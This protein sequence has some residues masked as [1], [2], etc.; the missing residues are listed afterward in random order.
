MVILKRRILLFVVFSFFMMHVNATKYYLSASGNDSNKG[1]GVNSPWQTI[2]R[3]NKQKLKPGDVIHF[4]RGDVFRGQINVNVSGTLKKPIVFTAYGE[5]DLPVIS[6]AEV[7]SGWKKYKANIYMAEFSTRIRNLYADNTIQTLARYPNSGFLV[8]DYNGDSIHFKDRDLRQPDGYWEGANVRMRTINWVY[9]TRIVDKY[10]NSSVYFRKHPD[11]PI[12]KGF[13]YRHSPDGNSTI[14][15][16]KLGSGYFFDN[17]FELLDSLGEWFQDEKKSILYYNTNKDIKNLTIESCVYHYG[18]LLNNANNIII[19]NLHL[20]KFSKGCIHVEGKSNNLEIRNN[21]VTNSSRFGINLGYGS[22]NCKISDN[23]VRNTNA[24]GITA[25]VLSNSE[26][27]GNDI[28]RVGLIPG[29][30]WSGNFSPIGILI[31]NKEDEAQIPP[32]SHHNIIKNNRIDSCGYSGIRMDGNNS[33]CEYNFINNCMLTLNDGG[34]FYCFARHPDVTFKNIIRNNIIMNTRG[35][36]ESTPDHHNIGLALYIDNNCHDLTI[37]NNTI[38]N[39]ASS[40]LFINDAVF[41]CTI[42]NNNLYNNS[43]GIA[44]A[45]WN[46]IGGNFGHIVENNTVYCKYKEQKAVNIANHKIGVFTPARMQNN[47]YCN[48]LEKF[49]FR[50]QT[51][52]NSFKNSKELTLEGWQQ[53]LGIDLNSISIDITK[54]DIYKEGAKVFYNDT[55]EDKIIDLSHGEYYN[56]NE[57]KVSGSINL[58]PF[59]SIILLIADKKL[60]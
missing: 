56:F 26:I 58:K 50:Y 6:G 51:Y 34:A 5:G 43:Q 42:L 44:F 46:K 10:K 31:C 52:H 38:I 9:E 4:K 36:T 32:Y 12:E 7:I 28:K 18:V 59:S 22:D 57:E 41:N 16:L 20:D 33:I 40:G 23:I 8:I 21:L 3:L 55:F 15:K 30:G 19:S 2:E 39:N 48:M 49:Y 24:R 25:G 29:Y 54:V 14:Y 17:K 45:E 13:E 47:F 35:N 60:K 37:E 11:H 27:S 53:E 1:T